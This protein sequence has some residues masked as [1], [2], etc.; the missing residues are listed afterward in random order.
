MSWYRLELGDAL[1]VEAELDAIRRRCMRAFERIG[2]PPG[3]AVYL[4]HVSGN[5]HCK[6]QLFFSPAAA[7]LA[8]RMGAQCCGM[9]PKGMRLVAGDE[10]GLF[11]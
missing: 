11:D 1:L 5:L 8:R 10:T 6:A 4:V 9:P 7:E 2:A 3:W